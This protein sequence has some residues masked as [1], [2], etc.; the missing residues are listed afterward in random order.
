MYV[1]I[2]GFF[3]VIGF[4]D[5]GYFC[6]GGII[7]VRFVIKGGKCFNGIYCFEESL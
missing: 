4:C 3:K 1:L 2:L 5:F 6:S 7:V